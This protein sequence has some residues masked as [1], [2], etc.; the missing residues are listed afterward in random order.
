M[1]VGYELLSLWYHVHVVLWVDRFEMLLVWVLA[2][3]C[4]CDEFLQWDLIA[5]SIRHTLCDLLSVWVDIRLAVVVEVLLK[6]VKG[7]LPKT[8]AIMSWLGQTA[9]QLLLDTKHHACLLTLGLKHLCLILHDVLSLFW[10][11]VFS[12][13]EVLILVYVYFTLVHHSEK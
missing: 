8:E 7:L 4:D 12:L 6:V 1:H 5:H 9:H 13:E 11:Q 3:L 2:Y 10:P